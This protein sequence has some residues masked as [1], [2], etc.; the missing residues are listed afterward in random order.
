MRKL[1]GV[2]AVAAL[3]LGGVEARATVKQFSGGLSIQLATLPPTTIPGTGFATINGS[4]PGGHLNTLA[5]SASPFAT[6]GH[7]VP[8]TDPA[9][10]PIKGLALTVHNGAGNFS[11]APLGGV[12]ALQ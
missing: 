3:V 9:A 10:A 4:A 1:L 6:A 8:V 5:L 11:G 2:L 12:M 7:L